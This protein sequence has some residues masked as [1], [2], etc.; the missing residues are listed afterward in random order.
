MTAYDA[1]RVLDSAEL[2]LGNAPPRLGYEVVIVLAISLGQSGV[3]SL[4]RI[5]ERLTRPQP[6]GQQSSAST[7]R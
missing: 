6:L 3:Y 2:P 5:I 7:R 4:L 1:D